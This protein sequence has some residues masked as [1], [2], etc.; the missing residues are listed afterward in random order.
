MTRCA[1]VISCVLAAAACGR[2]GAE[3]PLAPMNETAERY[4]KLVLA[5]GLHDPAYVDS[6]YG[7]PEWKSEV[8]Q[9]KAPLVD[10]DAEAARLIDALGDSNEP[11]ELVRLRHVYLRRQLGALRS[12]VRMLS[13]E[14]LSFDEESQALYDEVAPMYPESYFQTTL[15]EL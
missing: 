8:E 3:P 14:K 9:R 13:G 11:D 10:I 7:P 12:R 15:D 5:M 4:V 1:I 2:G 6:Y